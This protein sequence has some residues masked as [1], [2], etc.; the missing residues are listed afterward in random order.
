[1]IIKDNLSIER[2]SLPGLTHQTLAGPRDGMRHA[3]VWMQVIEPGC[4]TPVHR[5]D[6]EEVIVVLEGG[7]S[8]MLDDGVRSFGAGSTLIIA[9][10][11]VHKIVNSG[12]RRMLA[13]AVLTM[14]PVRVETPQGDRL[15]LPWDQEPIRDAASAT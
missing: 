1:M 5:H 6:C 15:P 14:A 8:C 9:P 2:L 13:I 12:D 3:E 4:E 10:N 11:V 7:G